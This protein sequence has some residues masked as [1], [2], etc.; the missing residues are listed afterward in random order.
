MQGTYMH[1]YTHRKLVTLPEVFF[2]W[3]NSFHWLCCNLGLQF[4][5]IVVYK[6]K[7]IIFYI[8][9]RRELFGKR[10]IRLPKS[11]RIFQQ[12]EERGEHKTVAVAP[13]YRVRLNFPWGRRAE[14][15]PCL[16]EGRKVSRL[17]LCE[18][19]QGW[20][21]AWTKCGQRL[22]TAGPMWHKI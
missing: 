17:P 8:C 10:Q 13:C 11:K 22:P 1:M 2:S 15:T 12:E 7:I 5:W 16:L 18:S 21:R 19:T 4:T 3:V 20:F 14:Q 9:N 6:K